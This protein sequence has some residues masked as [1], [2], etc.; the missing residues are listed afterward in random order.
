MILVC[1]NC[2]SRFKVKADAIGSAGRT[3]RCAKCG[4]KWH[5]VPDDLIDPSDLKSLSDA[6]APAKKARPAKKA[7]A[8]PPAP[9]PPP[10]DPIEEHRAP[11]PG[12]E[13]EQEPE[14]E[15]APPPPPPMLDGTEP[16]PLPPEEDFLPRRTVPTRRRSPLMAWIVLFV[17]ITVGSLAAFVF[18]TEIVTAYLPANKVFSWIGFPVDLLGHGLVISKPEAEAIIEQDSRRLVIRGAIENGTEET[19]EIPKMSASL[20]DANGTELA[21]WIFDAD[22]PEAFPGESVSYTTEFESP[23]RGATNISITFKTKEEAMMLKD[24]GDEGTQDSEA[25]Q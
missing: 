18:R 17:F 10:Q 20:L 8:K 4:H 19:I 12:P 15:P 22:K 11:E 23:P 5:A 21:A 7:A 3:V 6:S 14:I 24:G 16:P 13:P 1:P 9:E 2:T 25:A